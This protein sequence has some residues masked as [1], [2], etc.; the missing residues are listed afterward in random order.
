MSDYEK[1]MAENARLV[2]L[3]ELS[4]QT[5]SSLNDAILQ[6]VLETFGHV[7]TREWV[8]TQLNKLHELGAISLTPAGTA[9]IATL[10]QAGLDHVERRSVIDG[11]DRP[12]LEN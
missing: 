2:I 8:R 10:K 3:K 12:S 4:G 5:N 7:R 6:K 1:F 11:I 9:L